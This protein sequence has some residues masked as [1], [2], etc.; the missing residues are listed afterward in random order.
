MKDKARI[1]G[2]GM[3]PFTKAGRSP[4]YDAMGAEAAR[5]ALRDAGID[6]TQ[7]QQA[8]VGFV[9]GDTTSGQQALYPLGLSGIPIVNVNNACSS[10]STALFLARQAV[11]SGS[12]D[13]VLALGFE[14]MLA[15]PLASPYTD[16]P[17]VNGMLNDMVERTIGWDDKAPL[18]AQYFGSAGR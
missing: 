3:V 1:A 4:P 13:V 18:A 17:G 11:E 5:L 2:V 6:Y 14:Q 7:V 8:Y 9:I 16:R 15:G 12:A 10:G